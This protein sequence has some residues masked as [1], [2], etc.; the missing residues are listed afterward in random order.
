MQTNN[1][2]QLVQPPHKKPTKNVG[3][4]ERAFGSATIDGPEVDEFGLPIDRQ[5]TADGGASGRYLASRLK[6]Q[7]LTDQIVNQPQQQQVDQA[8]EDENDSFIE[9][10]RAKAQ[11][12]AAA[13][14]LPS[15]E[16][17]RNR[18]SQFDALLGSGS[19]EG[20]GFSSGLGKGK[21]SSLS[22]SSAS[23]SS[24]RL[25]ASMMKGSNNSN[26]KMKVAKKQQGKSNKAIAGKGGGGKRSKR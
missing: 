1:P 20:T 2:F 6:Q 26:G 22:S 19:L 8:D 5:S 18:T 12:P 11:Q 10:Q 21:S 9:G 17:V 13:F 23:S 25:S 15:N 16:E 14:T 24:S 4:F 3:S 7:A